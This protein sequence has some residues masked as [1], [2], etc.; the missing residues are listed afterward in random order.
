MLIDH[1]DIIKF[2]YNKSDGTLF[3]YLNTKKYIFFNEETD[4]TEKIRNTLKIGRSFPNIELIISDSKIDL[5]KI[6]EYVHDIYEHIFEEFQYLILYKS[7]MGYELDDKQ[8]L[9]S[10]PEEINKICDISHLKAYLSDCRKRLGSTIKIDLKIIDNSE[11]KKIRDASYKNI[12]NEK[13]NIVVPNVLIEEE[14]EGIEEKKVTRICELDSNS[15]KVLVEGK[16]NYVKEYKSENVHMFEFGL[17]DLSGS[18]ICKKFFSKDDPKIQKYSSIIIENKYVNVS[19]KHQIEKNSP[20]YFINADRVSEIKLSNRTDKSKVKRVEMNV[21]TDNVNIDMLLDTLIKWKHEAIGIMP[22]NNI[23]SFVNIYKKNLSNRHKL[24]VIFGISVKVLMD[25]HSA[26]FNPNKTHISNN[27]C[28]GYVKE[29]NI[30]ISDICYQQIKKTEIFKKNDF[31][32]IRDFC[33]HKTLYLFTDVNDDDTSAYIAKSGITVINVKKVFEI[34]EKK[35]FTLN[36]LMLRL[37]TAIDDVVKAAYNASVTLMKMFETYEEICISTANNNLQNENLNVYSVSL[38]VKNSEGLRNLYKILTK[39][40]CIWKIVPR[41]Y[42]EAHRY[43]LLV[44]TCDTK[45]ELYSLLF[46]DADTES[47]YSKAVF[48]DYVNL[49]SDRHAELLKESKIIK[50]ISEYRNFNKFLYKCAIECNVIPI[51]T[52]YSKDVSK[53][54]FMTTNEMISEF[55][56]LENEK[57]KEV[58]IDNTRKLNMEIENVSPIVKAVNHD[59]LVSST[60]LS[61]FDDK[62]DSFKKELNFIFSEKIAGI[63]VMIKDLI[64]TLKQ[65]KILF[66]IESLPTPYILSKLLNDN[67]YVNLNNTDF[68]IHIQINMLDEVFK[69]LEDINKNHHPFF[70]KYEKFIAV[71]LLPTG[72]GIYDFSPMIIKENEMVT[73]YNANILKEFFTTIFIQP[74][75]DLLMIMNLY[76]LTDN[77]PTDE[78]ID[79]TE[80]YNIELCTSDIKT[81][82]VISMIKPASNNEFIRCIGLIHGKG[83]WYDNA[84]KLIHEKLAEIYD[85]IC[86]KYEFEDETKNSEMYKESKRKIIECISYEE[87][88]VHARNLMIIKWYYDNYPKQFKLEY[89]NR[90]RDFSKFGNEFIIN[91]SDISTSLKDRYLSNNEITI[92]I[93]PLDTISY[94]SEEIIDKIISNR[95]YSSINEFAVKNLI[96]DDLVKKLKTDGYLDSL[97]ITDQIEINDLF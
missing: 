83:T 82:E 55:S 37:N 10:I 21:D 79:K 56:Y 3:I 35:T 95:P 47:I 92:L 91:K 97:D 16:I 85:V 93:E 66:Q 18:I 38:T 30:F 76:N 26:V 45:G 22:E 60:Y 89:I 2:Q 70:V 43:G 44:G 41:S 36:T 81:V 12:Q 40:N 72:Y 69:I 8:M 87:A 33:E 42:L 78:Q 48:Y 15:Y 24:K 31:I 34:L 77:Y 49:L 50:T 32:G 11:A 7:I 62:T 88:V 52:C 80:Y 14:P 19:G 4:L 25:D 5:S 27:I 64:I 74:N 13:S 68:K 29:D 53:R 90:Y 58:V 39:R 61:N 54:E 63:V 20:R 94:L 67:K 23:D 28:C 84:E 59:D 6:N 71:H 9:I 1:I 46:N 75:V 51:A 65:K 86:F 73:Q 57:A 17:N 96:D